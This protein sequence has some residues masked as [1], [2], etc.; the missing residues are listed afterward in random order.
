MIKKIK[1]IIT[2]NVKSYDKVSNRNLYVNVLT[3]IT[4]S[5]TRKDLKKVWV[6]LSVITGFILSIIV[7]FAVFQFENLGNI[8]SGK[9]VPFSIGR[10][11]FSNVFSHVIFIVLSSVFWLYFWTRFKFNHQSLLEGHKGTSRWTTPKEIKEQYKEVPY[12]ADVTKEVIGKNAYGE[13]IVKVTSVSEFS[14]KAGVIISRDNEQ[15][16]V[17]LDTGASHNTY[18]GRSRSGKTESAVIPNIDVAS[19]SEEKPH[20]VISSTKYELLSA[21]REQL[22]ARGYEINVLNLIDL[23]RGFQYNPL[24]LVVDSYVNGDIDEAIELCKTFSY[25]LYHNKE[26]REPVW[27]ESAMAAVNGVSLA[28]C[29]EFIQKPK[30]NGQHVQSDMVNLYGVGQMFVQL[31]NPDGDGTTDLDRYFISLSPSNPARM[32]YSTV[33]FA[34]GQMRSSIFASTQAKLRQFTAPAIAKLT[35][36]TTFDFSKMTIGYHKE[37]T[38]IRKAD[39]KFGENPINIH[40]Y[41]LETE[42]HI[43]SFTIQPDDKHG[44]IKSDECHI[45]PIKSNDHILKL[46][47]HDNRKIVVIFGDGEEKTTIVAKNKPQALFIVLPDFTATNYIIAST[48]IQQLYYYLSKYASKLPGDKLERRVFFHLDEFGNLPQFSNI[49]SMVS[50]GAGRGLLFSFYIQDDSQMKENYGET[51]AKFIRSQSMNIF[52]IHS[53]DE[54]TLE[55]FS[56]L[57]GN[58][59]VVTKSRSGDQFGNKSQTETTESRPLMYPEELGRLKEGEIVVYR[60]GT[61][62]DLKGDLIVPYPIHNDKNSRFLYRYEYLADQFEANKSIEELNLP[63]MPEI[64]LEK[65]TTKFSERIHML[66]PAEADTQKETEEEI[67][68]K[69]NK[70]DKE[71]EKLEKQSEKIKSLPGAELLKE[72]DFDE[73]YSEEDALTL[74]EETDYVYRQR[75]LDRYRPL[76]EQLPTSVFIQLLEE[77]DKN[78]NHLSWEFDNAVDIFEQFSVLEKNEQL[79]QFFLKNIAPNVLEEI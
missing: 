5:L 31:G 19:R 37:I 27:E 17:Y 43:E 74:N 4:E 48:F 23:D 46:R 53:S 54:D 56:E 73:I 35:A 58:K 22:E 78:Y 13:P 11:L 3:S 65:Y 38:F 34:Q 7:S 14:G 64:D 49:M 72:F 26:A 2:S 47:V 75:L 60:A 9:S 36:K 63:F 1:D 20:L 39:E 67:M 57:L 16:K 33:Q 28:Q 79:W 32:E 50:V 51:L 42:E 10:A 61:R 40:V 12:K 71:T 18:I 45:L 52:F 24:G 55:D 69:L 68:Q 21:T 6:I 8:L 30:Q 76:E 29:Y 41:H 77:I 25:P 59:E 62:R 44:G 66:T 70:I 15:K